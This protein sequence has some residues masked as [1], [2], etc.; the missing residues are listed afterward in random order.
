MA[1]CVFEECGYL[2]D[3]VPVFLE[4]FFL[5]PFLNSAALTNM[6]PVMFRKGIKAAL[7]NV[8]FIENLSLETA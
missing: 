4:D 7:L 5:R 2:I 6:R 8:R 3:R 1:V